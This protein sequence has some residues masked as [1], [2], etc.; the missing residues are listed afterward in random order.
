MS[1]TKIHGADQIM[2]SSV[3]KEQLA[4]NV[5]GNGLAKANEAD[6]LSVKISGATLDFAGVGGIDGI[7]IA[8]SGVGTNELAANAVDDTKLDETKSYVVA[9][10][11]MNGSGSN[12]KITNLA[13]GMNANDAVNRSQLDAAVTGLFW[14]PAAKYIGD[15]DGNNGW[16][17]VVGDR[18]VDTIDDKIYTVTAGSGDGDEVTWNAGDVPADGWAVFITTDDTGW[19]FSGADWVQ[20]TGA[21]Q[22]NAGTGLSKITNTININV[23]NGLQVT[24]ADPNDMLNIKLNGATLYV[25]GNGLKINSGGITENELASS[26]ELGFEQTRVSPNEAANSIRT[27]FTWS[28]SAVT[29][30]ELLFYNGVLQQGVLGDGVGIVDDYEIAVGG[31]TTT[32]YFAKAPKTGSRISLCCRVVGEA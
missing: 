32:V 2:G 11:A 28:I 1:Y 30:S 22:I 27:Q 6:A 5:A 8:T 31:G 21:G 13:N 19:N 12:A 7:K 20:F 3:E 16:T 10:L 23:G 17:L 25:D 29:G 14:Q 18:V 26:V 4:A 15:H 24:G 9:G